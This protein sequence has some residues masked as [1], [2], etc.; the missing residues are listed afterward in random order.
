MKT[1]PK[2][3]I[4]AFLLFVAALMAFTTGRA[5]EA[6]WNSYAV[7]RAYIDQLALAEQIGDKIFFDVKEL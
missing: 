7:Q 6:A 4:R 3:Y 2:K 1:K 5:Y